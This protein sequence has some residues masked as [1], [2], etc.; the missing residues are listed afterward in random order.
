M[1]SDEAFLAT[2]CIDWEGSYS[3]TT[4]ISNG[5]KP[6][7]SRRWCSSLRSLAGGGDPSSQGRWL[8]F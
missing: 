6:K 4:P 7:R 8:T 2:G 1:V 5:D 3:D